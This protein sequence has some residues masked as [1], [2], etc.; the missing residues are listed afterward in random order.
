MAIKLGDL[1]SD[2]WLGISR[3]IGRGD[4]PE[5]EHLV[6]ALRR[7][8]PHI[9]AEV[10]LYL[11]K[12]L[13][14]EFDRRGR[15]VTPNK[16]WAAGVLV[17]SVASS[18]RE[19]RARK[20]RDPQEQAFEKVAKERDWTLESTERNYRKALRLLRNMKPSEAQAVA[21]SGYELYL[22]AKRLNPDIK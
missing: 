4:H 21:G 14:G 18:Q 5:L 10:Q 2:A 7:Q 8:E 19:F 1:R 20:A 13:S 17:H 12:L 22:E 15:P 3:A 16:T 9:P 6:T 11:A